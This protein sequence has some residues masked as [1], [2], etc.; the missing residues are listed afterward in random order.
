ME[1]SA[2]ANV[3][4]RSHFLINYAST[5]FMPIRHEG[6]TDGLTTK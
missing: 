6:T 2:L 4:N 5:L 1:A 3:A